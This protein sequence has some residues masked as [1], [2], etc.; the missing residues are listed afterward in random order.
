VVWQ[1]DKKNGRL[2]Y[3]TSDGQTGEVSYDTMA[4]TIA[5]KEGK[6]DAD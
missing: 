6:T 3:T 2:T 5:T 1:D 4:K